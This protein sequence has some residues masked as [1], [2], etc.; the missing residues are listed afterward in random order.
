MSV[1]SGR[2]IELNVL[3]HVLSFFRFL[4]S[5]ALGVVNFVKV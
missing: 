2:F 1:T 5:Q 3:S 4:A